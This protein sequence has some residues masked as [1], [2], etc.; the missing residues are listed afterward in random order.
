MPRRS[1]ASTLATPSRIQAKRD[2]AKNVV[3]VEESSD[4]IAASVSEVAILDKK[5]K[6]KKRRLT[7]SEGT[8][9]LATE[10][11]ALKRRKVENQNK[12]GVY[13]FQIPFHIHVPRRR[14]NAPTQSDAT[15]NDIMDI[16]WNDDG[17]DRAT[18]ASEGQTFPP[19][20]A[21]KSKQR[22]R[23]PI[24]KDTVTIPPAPRSPARTRAQRTTAVP[25]SPVQGPPTPLSD[26][27][28]SFIP[29]SILLPAPNQDIPPFDPAAFKAEF[30]AEVTAAVAAQFTGIRE[31]I[32]TI[33]ASIEALGQNIN[34]DEARLAE[35]EARE[36]ALTA[37]EEEFERLKGKEAE[38]D[39]VLA[40]LDR[41][42]L[43]MEQESMERIAIKERELLER[44]SGTQL[45]IE[46]LLQD[47]VDISVDQGAGEIEFL[48]QE[49]SAEESNNCEES[50]QQGEPSRVTSQM[51]SVV[52]FRVL[53]ASASEEVQEVLVITGEVDTTLYTEKLEH[54]LNSDDDGNDGQ[55]ISATVPMVNDDWGLPSGAEMIPGSAKAS[56]DQAMPGSFTEDSTAMGYAIDLQVSKPASLAD[57]DEDAE[58]DI[59]DEVVPNSALTS[60][61]KEW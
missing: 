54:G 4:E 55:Q 30:K 41:R 8:D 17:Q 40:A 43:E 37:K 16:F 27:S 44:A 38:L 21:P 61:T 25:A 31:D 57:S 24:R 20:P 33:R 47:Q 56:E 1:A 52:P 39:E 45:Q 19:R 51:G 50:I 15:S 7:D 26:T 53:E 5:G 14:P 10:S 60:D 34:G 29:G 36:A 32:F 12:E 13:K 28:Q 35:I 58:A 59:D 3:Y 6:G 48:G 49:I 2:A 22:P 23:R 11:A 18:E 46:Q 42:H 9:Y